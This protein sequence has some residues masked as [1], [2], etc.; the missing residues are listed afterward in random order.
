MQQSTSKIF[1]SPFSL[2]NNTSTRNYHKSSRTAIPVKIEMWNL[3]WEYKYFNKLNNVLGQAKSVVKAK[4][5]VKVWSLPLF[6]MIL[7][8]SVFAASFSSFDA[9]DHVHRTPKTTKWLLSFQ[10]HFFSTI[11]LF[12]ASLWRVLWLIQAATIFSMSNKQAAFLYLVYWIVVVELCFL[13]VGLWTWSQHQ[14][15][16]GSFCLMWGGARE[17]L[18]QSHAFL[19]C[20]RLNLQQFRI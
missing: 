5:V 17:L 16:F 8:K 15:T 2:G 19:R 14:F 11:N 10:R 3:F 1:I 4:T 18:T 6:A 12:W 9:V 13:N 20:M 7:L